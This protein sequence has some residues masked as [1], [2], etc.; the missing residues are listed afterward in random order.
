MKLSKH[1]TK[2]TGW[3]AGA[4][5]LVLVAT[6]AVTQVRKN[7]DQPTPT[8]VEQAAG[9]ANEEDSVEIIGTPT[10]D[11][12]WKEIEKLANAYYDKQG[13]SYKGTIKVID[14]NDNTEKVIEEQEFEYSILDKNYHY[15]LANM[16]FVHK[17]NYL[18]AVD[19]TN[20]IIT[21][22]PH[23]E[24]GKGNKLFDLRTFK[25]LLTQQKADVRVTQ[26]NDEKI[27]TVDN[28]SDPDIQGYRIHYSPKTYKVHKMLIGML[29]LSPL[30]LDEEATDME[31]QPVETTG[32]DGLTEYYYYLEVN[33]SSIK[34]MGISI[35]DF[36]P[37][38]KFF[39][40]QDGKT[41]LATAFKDYQL[42]NNLE[43]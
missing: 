4:T 2:V 15:R 35:K 7:A 33:F 12:P 21:M 8:P 34:P 40:L 29:R 10:N 28:I 26:Y 5:L 27:I 14:D 36:K 19:H 42:Q 13:I 22:S 1:T 25:K 31:T 18:L 9:T 3:V 16:E 37:E 41:V 17:K 11:D 24:V 20:K 39:E 6:V 43:P 30:E 32:E 23:G 38:R